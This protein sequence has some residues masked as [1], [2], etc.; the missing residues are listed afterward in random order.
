MNHLLVMI[1]LVGLTACNNSPSKTNKSTTD[2][3]FQAKIDGVLY[4]ATFVNA[5]NSSM[6][7]SI[8]VTGSQNTGEEIGIRFPK[9]IKTG[10]YPLGDAMQAG[11]SQ[12]IVLYYE[13]PDDKN[14]TFDGQAVS[15]EL[16]IT[17][18]DAANKKIEGNFQFTTNAKGITGEPVQ[19]W[20]ITDG[21]FKVTYSDL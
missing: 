5:F 7:S 12:G 6:L 4:E 1:M 3:I 18:N 13:K 9:D 15:G 14:E 19:I 20:K 8:G 21:S 16:T 2:N 11:I 17:K 10:T